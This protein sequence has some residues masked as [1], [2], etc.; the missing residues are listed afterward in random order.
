[1]AKITETPGTS[2]R[3]WRLRETSSPVSACERLDR[4]SRS[5]YP[6]EGEDPSVHTDAGLI[7]LVPDQVMCLSDS[8]HG[9]NDRG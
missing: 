6:I 7:P 8:P 3:V 5:D 1:M 9:Q 4:L 2:G